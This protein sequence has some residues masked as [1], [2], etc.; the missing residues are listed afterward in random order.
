[1]VRSTVPPRQVSRATV[2]ATVSELWHVLSGHGQLWRRDDTGEQTTV[3]ERGVSID[4]PVG[5]A[6]QDRCTG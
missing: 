5:T 4:N 1:M 6:F 2:H 3:L